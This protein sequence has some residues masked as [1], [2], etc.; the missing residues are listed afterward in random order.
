MKSKFTLCLM[1]AAAI[2]IASCSKDSFSERDAIDAQKELLNLKYQH[3]LDLE[4]LK[5][6][7]ATALQQ[8]MNAAALEQLKLNDSLATLSGINAKKQ[9][10]SVSVVDVYTNTPIADAD[11]TVSSQGKLFSLKTNAQGLAIFSNLYLFPT[12]AFLITKTGYA[13]TQILQ[14]NIV[15]GKARLWNTSDLSNEI[16]GTLFIDTDLTTADPEKVG[17]NVLVTASA[18]IQSGQNDSYTVYFPTYTTATGSYSIKVPP[19]PY[20][21]EL[22]FEQIIADQK[23][24]VNATENDVVKTFPQTLPSVKIVKTYFNV[25]SY[26]VPIPI[27]NNYYYYKF[28]PDKSGRILYLSGYY[29][30]Y[31]YNQIYVSPV[32]DKFQVERLYTNIYYNQPA[33]DVNS[34]LYD[35][36]STVDVELVDITGKTVQTSPLLMALVN[37]AG[38]LTSSYSAEGGEGYVHLKRDGSGALVPNAKGVILRANVYDNYNSFYTINFNGS[39]NFSTAKYVNTQNL[40]LNKGEKKVVNFYYGSG[41]SRELEV[42]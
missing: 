42:Y 18:T 4:T 6:R 2:F 14:Q 32:N 27:V 12:S 9:D 35:V 5:Q 37:S 31:G 25:N 40:L 15:Y 3:E 39:V 36:N 19:A 10:Y 17:A 30:Y 16:T 22:T 1:M 7:G 23:L 38:K 11:V 8:L 13:A 33:T 28:S 34:Y 20:G 24:Y 41:D 26:S 29:N 21:Y